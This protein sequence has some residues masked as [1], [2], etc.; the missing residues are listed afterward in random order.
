MNPQLRKQA[1]AEWRGYREETRPADKGRA[2]SATLVQV[3][4]DLGL[5]DRLHEA[6]VLDTW[7]EIVGD[8][9][10]THSC[11]SAL[12]DGVLY[13]QVLQPSVH[14]ELDRNHK[15]L[16]LRRLKDRFG[17]KTIREVRFRVG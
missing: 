3:M 13:I 6:Q 7:K 14:F 4:R 10:A 11:P 16:V 2:V 5:A 15:R 1:L 12:R 17:E 9:L 8:F